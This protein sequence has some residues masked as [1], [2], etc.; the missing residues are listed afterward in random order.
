MPEDGARVRMRAGGRLCRVTNFLALTTPRRSR[1]WADVEATSD[2]LLQNRSWY[3]EAQRMS[4][5]T[6]IDTM[7]ARMVV[8]AFFLPSY[9]PRKAPAR[10]RVERRRRRRV[11]KTGSRSQS[12]SPPRLSGP[13]RGSG[14]R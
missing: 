7:V 10:P 8:F 4:I 13:A 12:G 14:L 2:R 5:R 3:A 9:L 1:S 11:A 6:A